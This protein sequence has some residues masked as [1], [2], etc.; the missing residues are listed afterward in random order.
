MPQTRTANSTWMRGSGRSDIKANLATD[1]ARPL[2]DI[3]LATLTRI[4]ST[5]AGISSEYRRLRPDHARR[6]GTIRNELNTPSR[7]HLANIAGG[8]R[9]EL[10]LARGSQPRAHRLQPGVVVS[11]MTHQLPGSF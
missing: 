5:G 6:K 8:E 7:Q 2:D 11:G 4:T 3:P 9:L 1:S 10:L